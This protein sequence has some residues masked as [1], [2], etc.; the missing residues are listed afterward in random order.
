MINSGIIGFTETQMKPS[1]STCKIMERLD[2]F[3]IDV[4]DN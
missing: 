2:F 4:N 3:N 1:D